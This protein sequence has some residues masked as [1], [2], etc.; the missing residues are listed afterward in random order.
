MSFNSAPGED[1]SLSLETNEQVV[2]RLGT[3]ENMPKPTEDELAARYNVSPIKSAEYLV[4][5][6][7]MTEVVTTEPLHNAHVEAQ[8]WH[9]R[10]E[11]IQKDEELAEQKKKE[12]IAA[13]AKIGT[14][15]S[16]MVEKGAVK[17]VPGRGQIELTPLAM[18]SIMVNKI[19]ELYKQSTMGEGQD[20]NGWT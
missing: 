16:A 11:S 4:P 20:L 12:R 15:F 8:S 5:G 13:E 2:A 17:Y 19:L 1:D 14:I 18:K 7:E 3:I 10:Q 9:L 6:D